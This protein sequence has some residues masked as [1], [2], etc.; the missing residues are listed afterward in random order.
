[1]TFVLLRQMG[2]AKSSM[3]SVVVLVFLTICVEKWTSTFLVEDM[4][5]SRHRLKGHLKMKVVS[6]R[7]LPF[8]LR[9]DPATGP[10]QWKIADFRNYTKKRG[11]RCSCPSRPGTQINDLC[12]RYKYFSC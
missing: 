12:Q 4:L 6:V 1:M 2:G 10:R 9:A 5:C 11:D 8:Q 7:A 3:T